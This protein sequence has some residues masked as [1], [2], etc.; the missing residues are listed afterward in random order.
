MINVSCS[1]GHGKKENTSIIIGWVYLERVL[2]VIPLAYVP[3]YPLIHSANVFCTY[4]HLTLHCMYLD[5]ISQA[6][7]SDTYDT[8]SIQIYTIIQ[9]LLHIEVHGVVMTWLGCLLASWR[10]IYSVH[11]SGYNFIILSE[12]SK[13]LFL[14][15]S[16]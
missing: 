9:G 11:Q 5:C 4:S 6:S 1:V 2:L 15:F 7:I 3:T 13:K 10:E 14:M 12:N 16:K 8:M